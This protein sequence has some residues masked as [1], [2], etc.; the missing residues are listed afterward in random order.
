[1]ANIQAGE[2]AWD[3][4][5]LKDLGKRTSQAQAV[6]GERDAVSTDNPSSATTINPSD[7]ATLEDPCFVTTTPAGGHHIDEKSGQ[8]T[9]TSWPEHLLMEQRKRDG[10][11]LNVPILVPQKGVASAVVGGSSK[12]NADNSNH[13][14]AASGW[15]SNEPQPTTIR[16]LRPYA[17]TF[18][19]G[20]VSEDMPQEYKNFLQEY[21]DDKVKHGLDPELVLVK[22]RP[23]PG[24][25]YLETAGGDHSKWLDNVYI[26]LDVQQNTL[27]FAFQSM[28]NPENSAKS[29]EYRQGRLDLS[30]CLIK[31]EMWHE[32]NGFDFSSRNK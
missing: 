7:S 20:P 23:F 14:G 9:T 8:I 18:E 2:D 5:L 16:L 26:R 15:F 24:K 25:L 29:K 21:Y 30:K 27:G 28:N 31:L 13:Q 32:S 19:E 22:R 3:A 10:E 17:I 4:L 12:E 11:D 6:G 1:M